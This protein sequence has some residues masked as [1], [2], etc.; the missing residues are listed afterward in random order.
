M[1]EQIAESSARLDAWV[2]EFV[3]EVDVS[4]RNM[5]AGMAAEMVTF[6]QK[7]GEQIAQFHRSVNEEVSRLQAQLVQDI[8]NFQ[9]PDFGVFF[10][11]FSS[12]NSWET[13]WG[14][15]SA[16]DTTSVV[17]VVA[18]EENDI[19]SETIIVDKV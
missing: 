13:F 6:Q 12:P 3:K 5:Q 18:I 17:E 19:S 2:R 8:L 15:E 7:V 9:V 4:V 1:F 10:S 11:G 16:T 14:K